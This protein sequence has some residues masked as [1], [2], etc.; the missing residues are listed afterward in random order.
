MARP[1]FW[2]IAVAYFGYNFTGAAVIFHLIPMLAERSVEAGMI[3]AVWV[4]IGPM[5]VAGRIVLI[6][7]GATVD[8]ESL[9]TVCSPVVLPARVVATFLRGDATVLDGKVV[10]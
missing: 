5:Q 8:R 7:V 10:R 4:T 6:D 2:G 1:A 3:V 9:R